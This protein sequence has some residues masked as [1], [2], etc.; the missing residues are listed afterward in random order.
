MEML[1]AFAG[2]ILVGTII[3]IFIAGLLFSASD[4][5]DIEQEEWIKEYNSRRKNNERK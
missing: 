1:F 3:G 4:E 2:G 5:D